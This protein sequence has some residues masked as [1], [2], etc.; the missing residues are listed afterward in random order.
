MQSQGATV[1]D[2]ASS[3]CA[4]G[5]ESQARIPATRTIVPDSIIFL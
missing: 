5:E 1:N 2:H 3:A 4:E